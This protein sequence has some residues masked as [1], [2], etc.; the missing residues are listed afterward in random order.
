MVADS[1]SA[2]LFYLLS[3]G[4]L[5][6][7]GNPNLFPT[8]V[9]LGVFMVPAAYAAFF[10]DH[11]RLST[12]GAGA[13]ARSFLYGGL[14]GV[15]AASILEPLLIHS[16]T[17]STMFTLAMIEEFAKI[18]G[19]VIIAWRLR[20]DAEIDGIIL[21]AAAGMGFAALESMGYAFTGFLRSGGSLSFTVYLTM[22]RGI[23]SPLGHGTWTAIL[24]A[25]LFRE[26]RG[27]RFRFTWKVWIGYGAAVLLHALWDL[28][29]FIMAAFLLPGLDLFLGQAIVG[30][31]GILILWQRWR[32][33]RQR[34][35]T[36]A[37]LA[38]AAVPAGEVPPTSAN[39]MVHPNSAHPTQLASTLGD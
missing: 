9:L 17:P 11:R 4:A 14:L 32:E 19:V 15:I 1:L 24:A 37:A 2:F 6:L 25:M 10:Y 3:L 18:L 28:L 35:E 34:Q 31:V 5:M 13:V 7:T 26:A 38:F 16:L 36:E 21:G 23:M 8:V 29:P 27:R 39:P 33:G 30:L 22:I 20:H 12:L